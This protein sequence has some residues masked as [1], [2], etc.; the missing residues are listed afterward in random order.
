MQHR[1]AGLWAALRILKHAEQFFA[2]GHGVQICLEIVVSGNGARG[3][4][5]EQVDGIA[6]ARLE[7]MEK[8]HLAIER[9]DAEQSLI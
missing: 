6:F 7:Q 4:G 3:D 2:G 1:K 8:L 5:A 9:P